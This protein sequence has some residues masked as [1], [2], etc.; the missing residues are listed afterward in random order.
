MELFS[1]RESAWCRALV[2]GAV[3]V[4]HRCFQLSLSS[5]V[6]SQ[7]HPLFPTAL[8]WGHRGPG[9]DTMRTADPAWPKGHSVLYD[10]VGK[11]SLERGASWA[12]VRSGEHLC[13]SL[14]TYLH[15][16]IV[17]TVSLF[18][19]SIL[20]VLSQPR[21][22]ILFFSPWF[23]PP[24]AGKRERAAVWCWATHR[25]KPQWKSTD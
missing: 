4:T 17:I 14:V 12:S 20:I 24:P 18:L 16:C 25:V 22:S 15:I 8:Q 1:S 23:S 19:F 6:C 2:L 10:M 13:A 11:E 9:G 5:A 7:G 3:L 21:S